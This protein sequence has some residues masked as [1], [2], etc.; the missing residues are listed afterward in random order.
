MPSY[1]LVDSVHFSN[2]F[3]K[4][5]IIKVANFSNCQIFAQSLSYW[6]FKRVQHG[7]LRWKPLFGPKILPEIASNLKYLSEIQSSFGVCLKFVFIRLSRTNLKIFD[8][9]MYQMKLSYFWLKVL[10]IFIICHTSVKPARPCQIPQLKPLIIHPFS[11]FIYYSFTHSFICPFIIT[12][13]APT[14]TL[15]LLVVHEAPPFFRCISMSSTNPG[16]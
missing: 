14:G 5:K 11:F 2:L 7:C 13:L 9:L 4:W 12:L 10:I 3:G 1:C 8:F 16:E 15:K 6:P